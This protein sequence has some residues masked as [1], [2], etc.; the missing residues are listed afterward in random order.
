MTPPIRMIVSLALLSVFFGS[1][2]AQQQTPTNVQDGV[3]SQFLP[4]STPPPPPPLPTPTTVSGLAPLTP[5]AAPPAPLTA[6]TVTPRPPLGL[7]SPQPPRAVP[8]LAIAPAPPGAPMDP[9]FGVDVSNPQFLA[10]SLDLM[11]VPWYI[12]YTSSVSDIPAGFQ[13]A[14]KVSS[15]PRAPEAELAATAKARPGMYWIVGNEPNVPGQDDLDP[16]VSVETLRYYAQAIKAADPTAKLVGPEILNF[17]FTCT[18]CAGFRTGRSWLQ[19]FRSTYQQRYGTDPPLDVWSLHTY[20]LQWDTLPQG[21]YRLQTAQIAALRAYLDE[22]PALRAAP[23]WLTEFAVVW[24]YDG[25]TWFQRGD[26][27]FAQPDGAF[28]VDHLASYLTDM[29]GWLR[30]NAAPLRIERWFVFSSHGYKETWATGPAGVYL[31]DGLAG[32]ARLTELGQLYRSLAAQT[33]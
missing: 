23:I 32:N 1:L 20:D 14:L 4:A 24:G 26:G 11:S 19:A 16:E 8:P 17:D 30:A 22:T 33:R 28:R 12:D 31:V 6:G 5:T 13:K 18:G 25:I 2:L 27:A 29:V 21:D 15:S 7:P 3:A 9:R 10:R